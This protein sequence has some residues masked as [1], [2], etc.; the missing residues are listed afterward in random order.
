LGLK[1]ALRRGKI[2]MQNPIN[3]V[4]EILEIIPNGRTKEVIV[5]RFGL[6]DGRRHTL[7]AI[8]Q[9]H[10]IT[11][12]R[13]RQIEESGLNALKH[14][15]VAAKLKPIFDVL[16]AHLAEHGELKKESR[17]YDDLAYVCYPA[18][19]IERMRKENNFKDMERCR[20]A[21]YLILTLGSDFERIVEDED[22]YSVWTLNKN[23]L[24]IAKRTVDSLVKHFGAKKQVLKNAEFVALAKDLFPELS[25]K[26]ILSYADASKNIEQN[27]LGYY[28]LAHWP[29]ISPRGVKDKAYIVLKNI[30]KPLHFS[31]VTSL[32]NESLP[33]DRQ[34]YVQTVHNELIKDPRFVLV[35]RG[36]Y[37]LSEW[38]YEPG[39]VAETIGQVLKKDGPQT[40]EE[41]TTKVLQ[42]RLVKENTILINLQNRKLFVKDGQGK[43]SVK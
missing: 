36:L 19:E 8:G 41:I 32:I 20:S 7:E 11:R 25:E 43:Y 6:S 17:L 4:N 40:K 38:G 10:G 5:R 21:F 24:K 14:A 31:G 1:I 28:G 22:F 35:G 15:Q 34:A 9:D 30:G 37:A 29:E 12:E 42:K 3:V 23:S 39:T 26:A 27:R 33:S 16:S 18:K 13:V 2:S